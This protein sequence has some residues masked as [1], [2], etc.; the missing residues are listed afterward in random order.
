MASRDEALSKIGKLGII[1]TNEKLEISVDTPSKYIAEKSRAK[2]AIETNDLSFLLARYP[3]RETPA[4]DAIAKALGFPNRA[5]YE[6]AARKLLLDDS[7]ALAE[8]RKLFGE[9]PSTLGVESR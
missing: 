2:S 5:M 7:S 8:V 1:S 3:I 9:L 6:R 4:L